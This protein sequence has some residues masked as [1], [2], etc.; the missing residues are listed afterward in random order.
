MDLPIATSRFFDYMKK[1]ELIR[2]RKEAGQPRPWTDDPILQEYKFTNV[3]RHYD[4]TSNMLR[5]TFY[6]DHFDDDPRSILMNCAVYR[7]FGTFEF[8][9]AV[10]WYDY[11]DFDLWKIED[12]ATDRLAN[13]ERVFTG[14]Y[15]VTN[16]GMSAPKPQVVC[17]H[18]LSDLYKAV[19]A[20]LDQ[21]QKTRSWR[22]LAGVMSTIKGFGG[23]G[24]MTKEVLL[25]TMMTGFWGGEIQHV[26]NRKFTY[27][28]D[29][30][31]W[32]PVGPGGVRG[33]AR[34]LGHDS[35]ATFNI[36]KGKPIEIIMRLY[37]AQEEFW[38]EEYGKL[39]PTDIQFQLCEFDKYERT[40]LG[41]G[42]PRSRYR[43]R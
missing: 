3:R 41:Q 8:A 10:G 20:L 9:K 37:E 43:P 30:D 12:C 2:L 27:P 25:D 33:A 42:R 36:G 34:L 18:F 32:T 28:E 21:V 26:D 13:G 14:A 29:Y 7:Y 39:F 6:S 4:W 35:P 19:P 31:Q 23:S 5:S 40:R 11:D 1:R 17:R 24:F 15:V 38:P 16:Q 22:D